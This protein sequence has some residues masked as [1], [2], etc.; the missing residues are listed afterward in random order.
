M[1]QKILKMLYTNYL[2]FA[3]W[4]VSIIIELTATAVAGGGFYIRKPWIYLSLMLILTAGM[5]AI[6][7]NR[8]RL[9]YG[10]ALLLANFVIDL[11]LIIVFEM[12]GTIFD[13]SMLTLR[14]DA[15]A[16]VENLSINFVYVSVAGLLISA[17]LVFGQYFI[18]RAPKPAKPHKIWTI[19][20]SVVMACTIGI[21]A[22]FVVGLHSNNNPAV[23]FNKLYRNDTA[24]YTDRGVFGTLFD[25]LYKG[26][27]FNN[28]DVGDLNELN[29]FIYK[30]ISPATSMTG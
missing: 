30:E 29:D 18:K 19:V 16:I 15:M 23:V 24:S 21:H 25:E 3:F 11:V 2:I 14:T 10:F 9:W 4:F 22:L 12:T 27:F 1:K 8:G 26:T 13:Y 5:Y 28:M 20:T 6:R 17:Y 7:N